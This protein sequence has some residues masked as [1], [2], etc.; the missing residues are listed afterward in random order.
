[1][2]FQI[3]KRGQNP[4]HLEPEFQQLSDSVIIGSATWLRADGRR[5][6]RF[7]VITLRDEKIANM[8]GCRSRREAERL[9]RRRVRALSDNGQR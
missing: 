3:E 7:Q 1:M 9:A 2:S 5:Q 8:Q 4:I 6:E